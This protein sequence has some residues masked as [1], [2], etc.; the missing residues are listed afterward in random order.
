MRGRGEGLE[1][2]AGDVLLVLKRAK[3]DGEAIAV[4]A[5]RTTDL[6]SEAREIAFDRLQFLATDPKQTTEPRN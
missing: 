2:G 6:F 4:G 5:G 1:L 3:L